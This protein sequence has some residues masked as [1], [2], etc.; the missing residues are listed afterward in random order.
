VLR[1]PRIVAD[2]MAVAG[3]PPPA[4]TPT[5][6]NCEPPENISRLSAHVCHTSRPLAT[7]SAPNEMP[8]AEVASTT[9]SA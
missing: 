2:A 7:A 5:S 9:D 1:T 6:A 4:T 3:A 8:Y